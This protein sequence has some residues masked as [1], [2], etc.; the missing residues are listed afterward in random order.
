MKDH[1]GSTG[2]FAWG[3][4]AWSAGILTLLVALPPMARSGLRDRLATHWGAS[5]QPDGSLPLWAAVLVPAAI[6][7]VL[8]ATAGLWRAA[9]RLRG[10]VLA[11]GGVL[12]A[13]AQA[14]IVWANLRHPDWHDA[15]PVTVGAV[16]T[17]VAAFAAGAVGV[18]TS[19]RPVAPAAPG[20][21]PRM[22]IPE[23]E[24]RVWL[25]RTA[26][27]WLSLL[28]AVT[29][30]VALAALLVGIGGPAE[31]V[32]SLI[33]PFAVVSIAVLVCSSVRVRVAE[34]GLDVAFGPFGWPVRHWDAADIEWARAEDRTPAQVGGWGYRLSG[35]GVTVMLRSGAC[36]VI[37]SGGRDFAVSVD[38]AERG[39]ALLNSLGGSRDR[40][41]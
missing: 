5:G 4:A 34:R 22:D 39:A 11:S 30:A 3:T 28:A 37:R 15:D 41:P 40:R 8:V 24:R 10:A 38:D 23:G 14:S 27:P 32:W 35:L 13:G 26:N 9:R 12:L 19:R 33:V 36:L 20:R 17:V 31:P 1:G 29:G 21:G 25:S 16:A 6:W 2:G 18:L 7:T